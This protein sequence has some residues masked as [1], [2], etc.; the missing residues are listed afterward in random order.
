M[1]IQSLF[2]TG[3][4]IIRSG[5]VSREISIL[6]LNI[7]NPSLARAQ[8]QCEWLRSRTEDVFVLTETKCSEGCEYINQF[9][10]QY[11]Y[12]LFSLN[13]EVRYEVN[14]PKSHTGDLGV[15]LISKHKILHSF[16]CF[17]SN[18][19]YY[20][21]QS[22][23]MINIDDIHLKICGLYV[24]SRNTE[25]RKIERKLKFI[26]YIEK[27]VYVTDDSNRIIIGDLN[28]LSRDHIPRYKTFLSWE[29][30]FYDHLKTLGYIDAFEHCNPGQQDYS[31]VGRT[32]DGYRYDYCFIHNSLLDFVKE[33]HFI[34]ETRQTR[35]T[36]HS[37]ILLT[38]SIN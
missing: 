14:F 31:W 30:D 1:L 9:F 12:D 28:I 34:H 16:N 36:D 15:M 5:T 27:Y 23:I 8:R 25:P 11:G 6:S 21:R 24:P 26:K 17:D 19:Q 35:L 29:Y 7:G 2:I 22:E 10:L 37:A 33:C 20:S 18:S 3:L 38:L 4:L 32:N 13:S